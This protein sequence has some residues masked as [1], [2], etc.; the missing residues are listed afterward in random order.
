MV[1]MSSLPVTGQPAPSAADAPSPELPTVED[2]RR[3]A[4]DQ[5]LTFLPDRYPAAVATHAALRPALLRLRQEP[6][7]F[8]QGTEPASALAW[9]ESGGALG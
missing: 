4:A 2:Y 9:V 1:V 3:L 8:L 5:G 7:P 6:M